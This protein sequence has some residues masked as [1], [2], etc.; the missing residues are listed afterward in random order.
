MPGLGGQWADDAARIDEWDPDR[1]LTLC[2]TPE[3]AELVAPDLPSRMEGLV[4]K[5]NIPVLQS[6]LVI[7]EEVS[8]TP[9]SPKSNTLKTLL[10]ESEVLGEMKGEEA[11]SVRQCCSFLLTTNHFPSWIET[12]DR[13]Y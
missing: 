8:V 13:R 4:A 9:G 5:F 3:M 7:C 2:T 10:T 6:K 12:D 11:T 1:I